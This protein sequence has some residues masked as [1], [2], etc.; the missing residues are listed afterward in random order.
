MKNFKIFF[1]EIIQSIPTNKIIFILIR[2]YM[3]KVDMSLDF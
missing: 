2:I 3:I 1:F